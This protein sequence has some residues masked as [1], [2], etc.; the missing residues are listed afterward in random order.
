MLDDVP[1]AKLSTVAGDAIGDLRVF[2]DEALSL[3]PVSL[4]RLQG[5]A[6]AWADLR[7][8]RTAADAAEF[9]GFVGTGSRG[10]RREMLPAARPWSVS[11]IETYLDCPFRFFAQHVL[12]L[13]EEPD[14]EETMD[15]RRQGILVHR[16]FEAFF[17]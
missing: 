11:A 5:A 1:H 13:E 7:V 2:N 10:A 8:S 14:D 9:H 3:H 16:V 15:P 6:R 17:E 12:K 4:D